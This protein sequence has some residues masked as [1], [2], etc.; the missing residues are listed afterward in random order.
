MEKIIEILREA[1]PKIW[2]AVIE[3]VCDGDRSDSVFRQVVT[4]EMAEKM[5]SEVRLDEAG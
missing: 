4:L 2:L 1:G 3:R 5:A